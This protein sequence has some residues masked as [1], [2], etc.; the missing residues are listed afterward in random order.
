M[1]TASVFRLTT[2]TVGEADSVSYMSVSA[3][4]SIGS[5]GVS[6]SQKALLHS[7]FF[8]SKPFHF[9]PKEILLE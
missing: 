6:P 4:H 8:V 7:I 3:R 1:A 2:A 9:R 5:K